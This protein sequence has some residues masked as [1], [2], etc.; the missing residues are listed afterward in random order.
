MENLRIFCCLTTKQERL[1]T[2]RYEIKASINGTWDEKD[3]A[4]CIPQQMSTACAIATATAFARDAIKT[5]QYF[6]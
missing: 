5:K 1:L 3:F 4:V 2:F 6:F